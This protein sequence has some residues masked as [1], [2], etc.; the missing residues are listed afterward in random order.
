MIYSDSYYLPFLLVSIGIYWGILRS[1][2]PRVSFIALASFGFLFNKRPSYA[3][4]ILG[5]TA[6]IYL[7]G[8]A[9]HQKNRSLQ[10]LAFIL[11][12]LSFLIFFKYYVPSWGMPL[13]L[14]LI[15]VP[16]G[17][18]YYTFK[19]IH[20]L[21]EC[22]RGK[23]KEGNFLSYA[24]YI[25]FFPMF[26]AG[27]IERFENFSRQ[28]REI[29]FSGANI[30]E[31]ME[32]ILIGSFKKLV[33]SDMF[34]TAMLPPENLF[35]NGAADLQW[36]HVLFASFLKFLITYFDFSGYTDMVIGTGLFFGFRLMENFNFP[37]FRQNLAEFWRNW[38]ISLS[39]WARDYVY[40]PLLI[41]YRLPSLALI[42]TMLTI[43]VWHS[44]EPGW[45]FWGLHHGIGLVLL[46][47]YHGWATN[48][49]KIQKMRSTL[50]WRIFSHVCVLWYVSMGYALTFFAEDPVTSLKL[51]TKIL[52]LGLGS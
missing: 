27:P 51:Y 32:R 16:L 4:F 47:R 1:P 30:S 23:F 8:R 19:H 6:V 28:A 24:A 13:D 26:M 3:L 22:Y 49:P 42:A 7:A 31:G 11:V 21:V 50:G 20:Y 29:K 10:L 14:P 37:L 43:G 52:F 44:A 25:F 34:L 5:M 17:I 9:L 12:P 38:H 39:S 15:A 40:F 48:Y 2:L 46:A 18:S 45:A 33:I 41:Q 35:V 36:Y